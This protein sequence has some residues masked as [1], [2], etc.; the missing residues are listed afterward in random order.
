MKFKLGI[1]AAMGVLLAMSI[2]GS[3]A[4][5]SV[6]S[7]YF[8]DVNSDSYSWAA[9]AVD[10]LWSSGIA[11]G[12]GDNKFAPANEIKRCDF[13]VLVDKAFKLTSYSDYMAN[14][15][16]INSDD[17]YYTAV[18]NAKGCG[19][20]TDN[21]AFYPQQPITRGDAMQML[22][23]AL[24]LYGYVRDNASTDLSMYSDAS[25]IKDVKAQLAVASLTKM[26]IISGNGGKINYT[27][28]MSRAEMAMVF[29]KTMTYIDNLPAV[30]DTTPTVTEDTTVDEVED[31][32][33]AVVDTAA[34]TIDGV[35]TTSP[36]ILDGDPNTA[37][38]SSSVR[39]SDDSYAVLVTNGVSGDVSNS[40][41]HAKGENKNAI[42][43]DSKSSV[44]VSDSVVYAT[45]KNSNGIYGGD[46]T[47]IYADGTKFTVDTAKSS[48]VKSAGEA[49]IE[50]CEFSVKDGAAV[51]AADN[52]E[53]SLDNVTITSK[54]L[55][56]VL[57]SVATKAYEDG[58]CGEIKIKNSTIVGDYNTTLF[59][60]NGNGLKATLENCDVS[61]VGKLVDSTIA[62][63]S[64]GAKKGETIE[65]DLVNQT[66]EADVTCDEKSKLV[67]NLKE[68][69]Y[70][71]AT[72]NDSKTAGYIEINVEAGSTLE[73]VND[74][75]VDVITFDDASDIKENGRIIYYNADLSDNDWLYDDE[76]PLLNG[77][78]LMPY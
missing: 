65:I 60:A 44:D 70:L 19:I 54:G 15:A 23:R 37:I 59:Y 58:D 36:V 68:G 21:Y 69:S 2:A 17:Y 18:V 38:D 31:D 64:S 49:E 22:Y 34:A 73:I 53:I 8:V 25:V 45:G 24:D 52:G 55:G 75:Y 10:Y 67:I 43:L 9:D 3:T 42:Q 46:A 27:D 26:G 71:K 57:Q 47:E 40:T 14:F 33:T 77:G 50:D 56:G 11:I 1:S 20:I 30:A 72:I 35:S 12:V 51:M 4:F 78:F 32:T 6:N 61:R 7:K 62:Y 16:D 66:L 48:A 76:Y 41:I 29:Y 28:T 5:A 13:V 63:Q 74:S 39:V